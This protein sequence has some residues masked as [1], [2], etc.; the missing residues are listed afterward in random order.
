MN[1]IASVAQSVFGAFLSLGPTVPLLP[2]IPIVIDHILREQSSHISLIV[3]QVWNEEYD[4][5]VIGA[6]SAGSVMAARLSEDPTKTVLLLEYGSAENFVSD[7]PAI[8]FFL[9]RTPMD[10]NFET[11][12]QF[13]S[14]FGLKGRRSLWSRGKAFGGTSALN[15][16]VYAR[17]N[18]RDYNKW[19]ADGA[20]GWSWPEIFPYFIK[21]EDNREPAFVASGYHG[22]GGPMT[23]SSQTAP[24][25]ASVA[26]RDS[27]PYL[28][29]PIGDFNGPIQSASTLTQ[30]NVRDGERL[31]VSK[32]YLEPIVGRKNLHIVA[33][34]FVTKI[35][36]N[37][38]N[39]A[40]GVEFDR[41]FIRHVVYARNEIILSAGSIN[42]PKI[43]MLSGISK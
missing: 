1:Q 6:G 22:V 11:E 10:W 17:G 30:K 5:I 29:Y 3:R 33:K 18:S 19:A 41:L 24:A 27:G 13:K 38:E 34:A 7:V 15:T 32:A 23:V 28:N 31:S 16:M 25:K 20:Y 36:F 42:S 26:Y 39:R 40:I 21:S 43:L 37:H 9:Q 12:P 35:L 4:Y 8:D 2:F 14:C